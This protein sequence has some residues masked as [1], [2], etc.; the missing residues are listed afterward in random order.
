MNGCANVTGELVIPNNVQTIGKGAFEKTGFTSLTLGSSVKEI[1]QAAF[2]DCTKMTG[3][4]VIPASVTTIGGNAFASTGFNGKLDFQAQI[5]EFPAAIFKGLN[6]TSVSF[7]GSVKSIGDHAF[8]NCEQLATVTFGQGLE[9]VGQYAFYNSGLSGAL[10]FPDSLKKI[11]TYAFAECPH[12]TGITLPDGNATIEYAAFTGDTGVQ[13]IKILKYKSQLI[14][15]E[16]VKSTSFKLCDI[17]AVYIYIATCNLINCRYAVKKCCLTASRSTH[18]S[19]EFTLVYIKRYIIYRFSQ[20]IPAAIIFL[21]ILNFQNI[22]THIKSSI[23]V[24]ET[25]KAHICK[26]LDFLYIVIRILLSVVILILRNVTF[27]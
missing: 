24:Y 6:F 22:L 11:D 4:L 13:K 10:T 19:N 8:E 5:E 16:S 1:G 18:N 14:S 23:S 27:L 26:S 7:S 15:S 12:I 3:D 20:V 2:K 9:T 21:Y 25:S 17:I